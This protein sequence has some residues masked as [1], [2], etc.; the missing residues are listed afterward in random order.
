[1]NNLYSFSLLHAQMSYLVTQ[2]YIRMNEGLTA[3]HVQK[4]SQGQII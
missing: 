4:D 3:H 1:M 2:G